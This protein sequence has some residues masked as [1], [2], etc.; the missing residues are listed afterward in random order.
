MSEI[1]ERIRAELDGAADE[2]YR[3]SSRRFFKHEVRLYG[4]RTAEVKKIAARYWK[5][6]TGLRKG[7]IL[8]RCE[9]LFATGYCEDAFVVC[10]WV[11]RLVGRLV[12]EDI[13]LFER[14][15]DLYIDNWATCDGLCNHGVGDFIERYPQNVRELLRWAGS[16]NRWLRRAAAVSLIIPARRGRYLGE[17]FEIAGLLLTDTDDMVRKGY[18][19]LLKEA[20]RLHQR[21]VFDYVVAHRG[22]MPRTALRYAIELMPTEFRREAMRRDRDE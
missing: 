13:A 5:E 19:W 22:V 1:V 4:V 10:Y 3:E 21:E 7:E 12:P 16:E 17:V 8:D 11:V 18:G 2:A 6:V 9:E 15:I 20:S 14:W